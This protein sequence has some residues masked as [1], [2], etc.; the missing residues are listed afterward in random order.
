MVRQAGVL[1]TAEWE[2]V[3]TCTG[4]RE[5]SGLTAG[6]KLCLA[7]LDTLWGGKCGVR[8]GGLQASL[9]GRPRLL[10]RRRPRPAE[11]RC[12]RRHRR[13]RPLQVSCARRLPR[14]CGRA[15]LLPPS[16]TERS[17]LATALSSI[18]VGHPRGSGDSRAS[19]KTY[20]LHA[21]T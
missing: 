11:R 12:P 13:E 16:G 2:T 8:A 9:S 10:G 15:F 6:A 20:L 5:S 4:G 21:F 19:P 1:G 18:G 14:Q 17:S 3:G 7:P